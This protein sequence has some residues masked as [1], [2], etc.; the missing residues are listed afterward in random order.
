M[1][2]TALAYKE[3]RISDHVVRIRDGSDVCEYLVIGNERAALIDTGYGIGDLKGFVSKLTNLPLDVYITHGHVDHASGAGQFEQVHMNLLDLPLFQ[4]HTTVD[5]RKQMIRKHTDLEIPDDAY[6]PSDTKFID[7][8][9]GETADLGGVTL[10][11]IHVPG[12]THG[13]MVPICSEDRIAFFGDACGVGVLLLLKES[14]TAEE[15]CQ[16]LKKLQTYEP[17]YDTVLRQHGTC[18]SPK[19]VLEDNIENCEKILAGTD[20]H[21]PSDVM[22][23]TC[24]WA[25]AVD[26]HGKRLDGRDGNIRYSA[27]HIRKGDAK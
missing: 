26:E 25:C 22:G 6:I 13:I 27:D 7:L 23:I 14:L 12:H 3:E 9:D 10:K 21:I 15:Y 19:T 11:F 18:S 16:S 20:A 8:K 1:K 5:F 17:L 24:Y 4:E 2:M